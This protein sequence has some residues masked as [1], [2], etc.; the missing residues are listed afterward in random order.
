MAQDG[1][2][3]GYEGSTALL[4]LEQSCSTPIEAVLKKF[5]TVEW[6]HARFAA[7]HLLNRRPARLGK[8]TISTQSFLSWSR[9]S[10]AEVLCQMDLF[11]R[12]GM[13]TGKAED[14]A[15]RSKHRSVRTCPMLGPFEDA[16]E[17]SQ[18]GGVQQR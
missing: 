8:R 9:E 4:L 10:P 6:Y 2:K 18:S 12:A 13:V 11:S 5:H 15:C 14:V 7:A 3:A 17:K 16:G 1:T